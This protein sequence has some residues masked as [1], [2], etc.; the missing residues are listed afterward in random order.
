M[1]VT[2]TCSWCHEPN[3]VETHTNGRKTFCWS[4]GHRADVPRVQCD[5]RVC[6]QHGIPKAPASVRPAA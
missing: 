5:C 6:R 4:C 3:D 1:R 2:Q